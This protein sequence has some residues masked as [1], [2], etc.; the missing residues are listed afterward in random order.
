MSKL[1]NMLFI[2]AHFV[3]VAL[4][5]GSLVGP[6]PLVDLASSAYVEGR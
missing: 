4:C 1:F 3:L 2:I 5:M 6:S